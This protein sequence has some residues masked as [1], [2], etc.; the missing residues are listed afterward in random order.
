MIN[1]SGKPLALLGIALIVLMLWFMVVRAP[2]YLPRLDA[3]APPPPDDDVYVFGFATL[4][5]PIVRLVVVGR[6]VPAEPATLRGWARYRRDLRETE[7]TLLDG[8]RFRVSPE[9]LVRLDRYEQTGRKYRRDLMLLE[10]GE[11]A[12]VYRLI[13]EKGPDAL[14]D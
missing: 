3:N 10:D 5:N 11:F 13:G 6:L 1:L 9:E 7:H 14:A 8:V 4:T 12:W 2:V